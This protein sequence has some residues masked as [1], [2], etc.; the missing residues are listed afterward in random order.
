MQQTYHLIIIIIIII[1]LLCKTTVHS[2]QT[3]NYKRNTHK[4]MR[5]IFTNLSLRT[6]FNSNNSF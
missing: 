5:K 6:N 1:T 4:T 2:T 3:T